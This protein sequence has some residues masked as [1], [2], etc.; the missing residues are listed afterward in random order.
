MFYKMIDRDTSSPAERLR[1]LNHDRPLAN[2]L[3]IVKN[4][5]LHGDF[6]EGLPGFF[7][8]VSSEVTGGASKH[9]IASALI[10]AT[11]PDDKDGLAEMKKIYYDSTDTVS[12]IE[13]Y[14][15]RFPSPVDIRFNDILRASRLKYRY[16]LMG[17]L[18]L[19]GM[20][21]PSEVAELIPRYRSMTVGQLS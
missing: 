16:D 1:V 3:P 9:E 8:E 7:G 18:L 5:M 2:F 21:N 14:A 19:K 13:G 10:I 15:F 11:K 6:I 4:F 20:A 12:Q 17:A